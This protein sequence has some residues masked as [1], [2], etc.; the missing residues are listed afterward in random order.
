MALW[1][2][3]VA[4]TY[5]WITYAMMQFSTYGLLKSWGES[6]PDPFLAFRGS[7]QKSDGSKL[8]QP[9]KSPSTPWKTLVLFIAGAGKQIG[10]LYD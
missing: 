3:N 8:S 1:K 4:A 10:S 2:G 9:S 6:I 7:P 5:L